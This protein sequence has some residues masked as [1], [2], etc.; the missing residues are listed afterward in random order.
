MI[1][2]LRLNYKWQYA[3]VYNFMLHKYILGKYSLF[4]C[5][6]NSYALTNISVFFFF[7]KKPIVILL[8]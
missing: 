5:W 4:Y 3:T 8:N 1:M 6:L 7:S 2:T